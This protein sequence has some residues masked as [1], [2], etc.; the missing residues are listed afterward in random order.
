MLDNNDIVFGKEIAFYTAIKEISEKQNIRDTDKVIKTYKKTIMSAVIF[1]FKLYSN[2]IPAFISLIEG[3]IKNHFT[4]GQSVSFSDFQAN[5]IQKDGKV[6]LHIKDFENNAQNTFTKIEC[7]YIFKCYELVSRELPLF[8][9]APYTNE[10]VEAIK[11][12]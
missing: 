12:Y 5:V 10:V 4:V 7:D 2:R 8:E 3:F 9:C 1:N 11:M 6:Y